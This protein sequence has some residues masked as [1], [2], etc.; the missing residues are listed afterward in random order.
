MCKRKEERKR[1]EEERGGRKRKEEGRRGR[2]RRGVNPPFEKPQQREY[3][4]SRHQYST[5]TAVPLSNT[6]FFLNY[7]LYSNNT[8]FYCFLA[9]NN[10]FILF[11]SRLKIS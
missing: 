2:G 4:P 10:L 9:G 6:H 11:N 8:S 3:A 1:E 5:I 7:L